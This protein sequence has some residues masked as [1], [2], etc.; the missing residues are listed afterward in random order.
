MRILLVFLLPALVA[1][2]ATTR[3]GAPSLDELLAPPEGPAVT[4]WT[5]DFES[6]REHI[7]TLAR[8]AVEQSKRG[9]NDAAQDKIDEAR[10]LILTFQGTERQREQLAEEY[11]LLL[12]LLDELIE[13]EKRPASEAISLILT[14]PEA[15]AQDLADVEAAR[16]IPSIQ[17]YVS[18][19]SP[20][21]QKRI[22]RQ[23]A[24]FT[25]TDRGRE[26]FQRYLDRS[27]AYRDTISRLL[28]GRNLPAELFCVALIESGFS[29]IAVSRT[30]AA[31]MWQFMPATGRAYGLDQ[32]RWVDERL[33]WIKATDAAARYFRD[34][35]QTFDGDIELAVASYNTG[36][37]N[38]KKAIRKA[39]GTSDF[40]RLKLHP[41][42]MDYVPKWIAAMIIYYNPKH[43][44]F[45]VPPDDPPR[46]DDITI[47]GSLPLASIAGA[48][49]EHPEGI[50]N[51]NRAL[52]RKAT[53]PDRPWNVHLPA[54]SRDKL[55]ANL[56]RLLQSSSVVWLAHRMKKGET[57]AQVAGRYGVGVEQLMAVNDSLADHLP[58]EGE[59]IMVPVGADNTKAL[60]DFQERQR[61]EEVLATLEPGPGAPAAPP[62][63]ASRR[64]APKKI[65]HTVRSRDNLW[66]IAQDYDVSV[67][68]LKRWNQGQIG[69]GNRIRPGQKLNINLGEAPDQPAPVRYTVMRGD[70]LGEIAKRF[71]VATADLAAANGLGAGATIYPGAVLQIPGK[72]RPL[73]PEA[74]THQVQ[75]GE[76]ITRIAA[77]NGVSVAALMAANQ[78]TDPTS[79]QAGQILTIPA[80][81]EKTAAPPSGK[82]YTVKT[83]DTLAKLAKRF[84][85]TVKELAA[86]NKL[87]TK[88][89]LK[90][91]QKLTIPAGKGKDIWIQYKVRPGDTLTSIAD[92]FNCTV[93]D[94]EKWNRIRR[95]APLAVGQSLKVQ[96]KK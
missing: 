6:L 69:P 53:P 30:G 54:G 77:D 22:A 60:A 4:Q 68:D 94:L 48:I 49:G 90:A 7:R 72:G 80:P 47:R 88:S 84:G 9:K 24:V 20:A 59:V 37:G 28:A 73:A 44:G 38:V 65:V 16:S 57:V 18:R 39:G 93:G 25:R 45:T 78:L 66:S 64:A 91:G 32:D 95:G 75:R 12:T 51:L 34:S 71:G 58:D 2:C 1:A 85:V 92:H 42:T 63:P 52:I 35:L 87:S 17:R 15:T 33:D 83:G 29:E 67:D 27:A 56:D 40:W 41:E 36:P 10:R 23:L 79:L 13:P 96:V 26:L 55:V 50:N 3:R 76:N 31:G 74:K 19:L 21:A 14:T 62:P 81:G 61:E 70:T 46:F 86:A 89:P 5:G 82:P 43:Y 8:Q 11:E